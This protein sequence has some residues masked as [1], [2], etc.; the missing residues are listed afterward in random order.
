MAAMQNTGQQ[1]DTLFSELKN[2]PEKTFATPRCAVLNRDDSSFNYLSAISPA[3]QIHYGLAEPADLRAEEISETLHG[4]E[5]QVVG[6][7]LQAKDFS[8]PVSTGLLGGYNVSNCLAAI[9]ACVGALEIDPE[10]AR[11]SLA[12]AKGVPGRMEPIHMG[13]NFMAIVD[14]AHTPNALKSALIAARKLTRGRVISVFGSAGLRDRAKRRMMAE[15][16]AELAD[17]TVLTAEDPRTESLDSILQEM[18]AGMLDRG[19]EEGKTFWRVADRG[20]ALRF[21]LSLAQAGDL[22][23]AC[24]KGHEQSMCFGDIEYPWD[25]RTALRAALAEILHI[26]GP[27]DA[28]LAH[29][30]IIIAAIIYPPAWSGGSTARRGWGSKSGK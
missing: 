13:Q 1:K 9:G 22:V 5:F 10:A 12:Q 3:N 30:K 21:A 16:S 18:A 24:G 27:A 14:F 19:G 29:Q 17:F 2:T 15:T 28:G 4:L 7:T 25:D 20:D 23:I 26:P 11:M 6:K 8:F